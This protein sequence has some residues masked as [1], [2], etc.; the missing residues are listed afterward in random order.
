MDSL[1]YVQ[2]VRVVP[3]GDPVPAL[4]IDKN[5]VPSLPFT[6]QRSSL[7]GGG[8][9][10][11]NP[12]YG[13]PSPA[14]GAPSPAYGA[15]AAAAAPAYKNPGYGAPQEAYRRPTYKRETLTGPAPGLA[16]ATKVLDQA[17]LD[18]CTE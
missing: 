16:G 17:Y 8:G 3:V 9:G 13:V 18:R 5:Y 12:G 15:P 11:P 2:P 14:Y 10:G 4:T 6:N 7:G 1:N